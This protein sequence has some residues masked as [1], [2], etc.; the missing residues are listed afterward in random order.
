MYGIPVY[1]SLRGHGAMHYSFFES[2]KGT[3]NESANCE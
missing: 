2:R 1:L 3:V